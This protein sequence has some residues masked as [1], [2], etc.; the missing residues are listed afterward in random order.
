MGES[1]LMPNV[2]I[3]DLPSAAN[4]LGTQ[5]LE[6]NDSGVS[7][8][9]TGSQM[10][11]MVEGTA[12]AFVKTTTDQSVGGKKT[13]NEKVVMQ[14]GVGISLP[15]RPDSS[16]AT[17]NGD[18]W[19]IGSGLYIRRSG[20]NRL[21][22]D[23]GSLP[24]VTQAEAEAGVDVNVKTWSPLRVKQA[25][26]ASAETNVK[27]AL[28]ATGDAPI[29]ACRA[30]VNFNGNTTPPTIRGSGNISSVSRIATG[31]YTVNF[32]TAMPDA[33]YAIGG[34]TGGTPTTV[35]IDSDTGALDSAFC[36]VKTATTSLIN[37]VNVTLSFF[38]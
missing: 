13:F 11:A 12:T 36:N 25:I 6:V 7:R 17:E 8:K 23:Q 20:V 38:R 28:N 18:V 32:A 21:I 37:A 34:A 10:V 14:G 30:W 1:A 4:A 24:Q 3:S 33:D 2:K 27:D 5:E 29:Y 15:E 22:Y 19:Q 16:N 26:D 35:A 9:V 31:R